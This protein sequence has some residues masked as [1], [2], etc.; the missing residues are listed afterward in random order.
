HWHLARALPLR[1]DQGAI[2]RW[3]GTFTDIGEQKR[4]EEA[5]TRLAAIVETSEDAIYSKDL[6]GYI[7]SWNRGAEKMYGYSAH[8]VIGQHVSVLSP[9]DRRDEIEEM[10]EMLRH[11]ESIEHVE[12]VRLSK[13]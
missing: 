2:V 6:Q 10:L 1:E 7:R 3:L 9:P 11:G 4:A 5:L 12:T 13:D 8:E